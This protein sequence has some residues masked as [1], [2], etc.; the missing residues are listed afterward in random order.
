[1]R[2]SW[3]VACLI[4]AGT[5]A[6]A[7]KPDPKRV[8]RAW[9]TAMHDHD[10]D[11]AAKLSTTPMRVDFCADKE[12]D[13]NVQTADAL[14]TRLSCAAKHWVFTSSRWTTASLD[15]TV[16]GVADM[17]WMK[18]KALY[19]PFVDLAGDHAVLRVHALLEKPSRVSCA[20]FALLVAIDGDRVTAVAMLP[21]KQC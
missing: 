1:M 18:G 20:N 21:L 15:V 8:A 7:D 16:L 9:M 10:I 4:L 19:K 12:A 3:L 17:R 6:D 5:V 11:A 14:R 2:K 13:R